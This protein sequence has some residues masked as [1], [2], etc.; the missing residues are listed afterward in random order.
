MEVLSLYFTCILTVVKKQLP[1]QRLPANI[2]KDVENLFNPD[3]LLKVGFNIDRALYRAIIKCVCEENIPKK[4]LNII[5]RGIESVFDYFGKQE[6]QSK[7][8][9]DDIFFYYFCLDLVVYRE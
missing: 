4:N 9:K 3:V 8:T 7:M 5:L 1:R 2:Q 6:P